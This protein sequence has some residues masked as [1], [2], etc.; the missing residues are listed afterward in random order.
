MKVPQIVGIILIVLG[1]IALA[2]QGFSWRSREQRRV[3][4]LGPL[5]V[6]AIVEE[7]HHL[8]LPPI[9]GVCAM[10]GGVVLLVTA[11]RRSGA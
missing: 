5:K 9:L 6:D 3:V 11:S 7:Q 1:V 4:D 8:P 10:A 2:Y